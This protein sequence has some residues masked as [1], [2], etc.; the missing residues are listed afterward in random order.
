VNIPA[1][2]PDEFGDV[3]RVWA[4]QTMYDEEAG[5]Y[6]IYFSMKKRGNHPDIM[7]MQMGISQALNRFRDSCCITR[8]IMLALMG[9]SSGKT[10][11]IICFIN[12]KVVRCLL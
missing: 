3:D 11:G 10:T 1:S 5:R 4:P 8:T 12:R 6:M 2:F 9:I 7:L